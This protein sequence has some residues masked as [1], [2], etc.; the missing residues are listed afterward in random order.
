MP[1][2]D[3]KDDGEGDHASPDWDWGEI[4]GDLV[5]HTSIPDERIPY[6]TLPKIEA[7]RKSIGRNVSLK[8]G[9]PNILSTPAG[10]Q[11]KGLADKPPKLSQ[12]ASF[13]SAFNG[14]NK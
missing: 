9:I 3:Q 7:Y 6:F 13:A 10:I 4:F 5:C 14:L 8:M 2:P 1:S 11:P 12:F